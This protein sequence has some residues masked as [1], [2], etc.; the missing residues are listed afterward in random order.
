MGDVQDYQTVL[1]LVDFPPGSQRIVIIRGDQAI[2]VF[3]LSANDVSGG[4]GGIYALD[5]RC[6]HRGGS[7]G[8]GHVSD[9]K[10]TCPQHEWE[11]H[12]D[13]GRCVDNPEARLKC[14]PVRIREGAIQICLPPELPQTGYGALFND[15]GKGGS[16]D[17]YR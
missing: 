2:A 7:I 11:F 14:Y 3:H 6:V 16:T 9:G 5:N 4:Q 10:V 8:D 15:S 13:S 17:G 12:V 1:Q